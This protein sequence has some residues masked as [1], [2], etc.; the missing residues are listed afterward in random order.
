MHATNVWHISDEVML[1]WTNREYIKVSWNINHRN[2]TSCHQ[3]TSQQNWNVGRNCRCKYMFYLRSNTVKERHDLTET[4]NSSFYL[5]ILLHSGYV[6]RKTSQNSGRML[7][8]VQET[9]V[10][11]KTIYDQ[12]CLIHKSIHLLNRLI[13]RKSEVWLGPVI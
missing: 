10:W 4:N 1:Q 5:K 7:V 8:T 6:G 12:C 2:N 11:K 3:K 9:T 13:P